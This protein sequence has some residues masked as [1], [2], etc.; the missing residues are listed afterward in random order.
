MLNS[1]YTIIFI[2]IIKNILDLNLICRYFYKLNMLYF[3]IKHIILIM[4][5]DKLKKK[6]PTYFPINKLPKE[7]KE[8]EIEVFRACKYGFCDDSFLTTYEECRIYKFKPKGYNE[9]Y[10]GT[11]S[12][13]CYED[14]KDLNKMLRVSKIHSKYN[15]LVL[16]KGKTNIECGIILR[17]NDVKKSGSHVDFWIYENAKPIKYFEVI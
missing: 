6:F 11:Y 8:E 3:L 10:I 13:S 5:I 16:S 4:D 17:A 7:A 12:M 9:E 1:H 15:N 14:I 2:I